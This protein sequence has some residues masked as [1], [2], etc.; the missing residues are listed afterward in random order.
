M[1][2][3]TVWK[4]AALAAGGALALFS[5]AEYRPKKTE[6]LPRKKTGTG[7]GRTLRVGDELSLLTW[8][9]GFGCF[10]A[11]ADF[12]HDGGKKVNPASHAQ[13]EKN[14]RS[15]GDVLVGTRPDVVFIQEVDQRS[16]RS[17]GVDEYGKLCNRM[18]EA[19]GTVFSALAWN[20]KVLFVPYP[21]PPIGHV[22]SGIATMTSLTP[23]SET[24]VSLPCPFPW[25]VRTCNLKRCLLI[26]RIP[27]AESS[28]ELVLVNLHLEAYDS[29][30]G[31]AAQT[32]ALREVLFA[33]AAR[34]NYVIAG[35]DFNQSFSAADESRYPLRNP[36]LW[37]AGKLDVEA[38]LPEFCLV[39]DPS[40]PSCRS[41]DRPYRGADPKNFQYYLIDG[42]LVSRNVEILSVETKDLHFAA[43]DHNPVQLTCRLRAE[44]T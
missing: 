37:R 14:I 12:F 15:I 10:D 39:E 7:V 4:A 40:V 2:A 17:H 1:R 18:A 11:G 34:G 42:Y 6:A 27:L 31:K 19:A 20:F 35:G 30:E 24:R 8:N 32:R 41:L 33:E 5:A 22:E 23:K 16:A 9:I 28:R 26:T 44:Q 38:F 3:G 13:V 43:S 29:G 36:S 25:P 21:I